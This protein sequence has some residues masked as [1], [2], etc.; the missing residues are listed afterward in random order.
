MSEYS[1]YDLGDVDE[2]FLIVDGAKIWSARMETDETE[3]LSKIKPIP[4]EDCV[5]LELWE[6]DPGVLGEDDL[7][8]QIRICSDKKS[9]SIHSYDFKLGTAKYT[10]NYK[11]E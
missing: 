11:V 2:P 4:F 10:L 3:D 7:L 5:K 1:S 6:K 9:T 8:G